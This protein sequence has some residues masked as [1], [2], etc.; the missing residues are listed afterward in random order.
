LVVE[1]RA[2]RGDEMVTVIFEEAGL[3]RLMANI[4]RLDRLDE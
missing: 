4:A 3:K 1:S 2:D